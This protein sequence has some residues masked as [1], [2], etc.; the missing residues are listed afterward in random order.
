MNEFFEKAAEQASNLIS[1]TPEF[2]RENKE[3]LITGAGFLASFMLGRW[4]NRR[5]KKK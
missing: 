3:T 1:A 5:S 4:S 2:C